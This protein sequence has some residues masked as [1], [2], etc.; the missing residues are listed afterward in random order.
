M[1]NIW[2]W[3]NHIENAIVD[4]I[5]AELTRR[6]GKTQTSAK[7]GHLVYI[8]VQCGMKHFSEL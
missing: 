6:T 4:S 2:L 8:G 7:A 5:V 3:K 1:R